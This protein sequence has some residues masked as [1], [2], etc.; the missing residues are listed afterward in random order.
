MTNAKHHTVGTEPKPEIETGAFAADQTAGRVY[1]TVV[2]VA[3]GLVVSKS[4]P[5]TSTS[6]KG[7][8]LQY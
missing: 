2:R 7:R 6:A 1:R 4:L 8:V 5:K 3:T